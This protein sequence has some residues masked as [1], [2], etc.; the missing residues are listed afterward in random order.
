[1]MDKPYC[2]QKGDLITLDFDP[3]S[4]KEQ[5]G[6][7]PAL[8]ISNTLFNK[9]TGLAIV[10]PITRTDRKIPLHIKIEENGYV[11]GFVMT[12]QIRSVDF[13]KRK[14]KYLYKASAEIMEEVLAILHACVFQ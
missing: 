5:K 10:C 14:A 9:K 7:R 2:P 4:A 1:M 11:S 13:V 3:R 8:V 6:R 12:E